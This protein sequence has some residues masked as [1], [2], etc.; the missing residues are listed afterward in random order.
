VAATAR[1]AGAMANPR[2]RRN[3]RK[4]R[5]S[6]KPSPRLRRR[7]PPRKTLPRPRH[8]PRRRRHHRKPFRNTR[9]SNHQIRP[10]SIPSLRRHHRRERKA[11]PSP[12]PRLAKADGHLNRSPRRPTR[13]PGR[14]KRS[15]QS[16]RRD[17]AVAVKGPDRA[18]DWGPV[19]ARAAPRAR[20]TVRDAAR[21][22]R[23]WASTATHGLGTVK[24]RALE[25]WCSRAIPPRPRPPKKKGGCSCG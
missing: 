12:R 25:N 17:Q 7:R 8:R 11:P 21:R 14:P 4:P 24:V 16:T 15:L 22:G 9:P 2:A 20:E 10:R 5:A 6:R 1:L 3:P 13:S 18:V 23:D 19:A